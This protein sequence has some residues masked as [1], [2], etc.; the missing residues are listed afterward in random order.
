MLLLK[1]RAFARAGLVGNPSDGYN[2]QTLS[3]IVR[4]FHAEVVLYEWEEVEVVPADED[5]SRFPSVR[6]LVSDVKLHGYYGG[7]RLVKAAIKRFV[8]YC[9]QTGQTLHS[10]N[11]SIRYSSTIPRQVGLAGSSAIVVATVRALT[12]FYGIRIPERVQPSLVL[13][14]ETG[15]LGIIAGLQ[16]R[17]IQVYEG[18]VAMDFSR[19]AMSEECGYPCGAYERI[20]PDLLPPL[21][22]AYST[23]ASEPTEVFHNRLRIRFDQGEPDVVAAMHKFARL[24][25]EA[26]QALRNSDARRFS[27]L[28]NENFD[29]RRSICRLPAEHIEMV[30]RARRVGASAKFAGSGGAIVGTYRDEKMFRELKAELSRLGCEVVKP[31]IGGIA[32]PSPNASPAPI[33]SGTPPP[34][35][36]DRGSRE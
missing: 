35:K 6:D 4:N 9:D 18:L 5:H 2:G 33:G 31:M 26:R 14:V 3:L 15:E 8:E 27:E 17:V 20:E 1:K 19:E 16:D 25:D 21:Y 32:T 11:F 34:E 30:E 23:A 12:E 29:T 24:A 28:M 13:S 10:R 36:M 22:L 7:I